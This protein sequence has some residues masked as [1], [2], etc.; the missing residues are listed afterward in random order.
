LRIAA[1]GAKISMWGS[2]VI[3]ALLGLVAGFAVSAGTFAFIIALGV[4]PRMIGKSNTAKTLFAYETTVFF[5]GLIGNILSVFPDISIP[6][7][8]WLLV[9]YGLGAG[10]FVGCIAVSLAEIL[11]TFPIVFRRAKLSIG[12]EWVLTFMALGKMTGALFYFW[13]EYQS[14]L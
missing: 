8:R 7:G 3:L 2:H 12:L 11:N 4:I 14:T 6:F 1:E 10:I 5:G 13:N 9:V